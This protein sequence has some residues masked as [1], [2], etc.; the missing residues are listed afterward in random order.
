[1]TK[2]LVWSYEKRIALDALTAK[3]DMEGD[4]E[5][6]ELLAFLGRSWRD[7]L[8]LDPDDLV[9]IVVGV[10][11]EGVEMQLVPVWVAQMGED[12][13]DGRE[14]HPRVCLAQLLEA[15]GEVVDGLLVRH[16]EG[17]ES[18]PALATALSGSSR[19]M[20]FGPPFG[21]RSETPMSHLARRISNA[22]R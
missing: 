16:P 19:S 8:A 18:N 5:Q 22:N 6:T 12:P 7:R 14:Y 17:E 20:R 9:G 13:P 3:R 21:W 15:G 2:F 11:L 1:M 10:G 4:D